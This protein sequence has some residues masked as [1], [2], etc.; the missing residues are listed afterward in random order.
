MKVQGSAIK[1]LMMRVLAVRPM[2]TVLDVLQRRYGAVVTYEEPVYECRCDLLGKVG[3]AQAR[4]AGGIIRLGWALE[5]DS[6]EQVLPMLMKTQIRPR[7]ANR[8][9]AVREAEAG[10]Y[11]VYPV[12]ARNVQGDLIPAKPLMSKRITLRMEK[13]TSAEAI[14]AVCAAV[15]NGGPPVALAP[16]S[17]SIAKTLERPL[18]EPLVAD[19]QEARDVLGRVLWAAA[20]ELSWQCLF[21][22]RTRKHR[23]VVYDPF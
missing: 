2:S 1:P 7:D 17:P 23:L 6:V 20:P 15:S 19:A 4:L 22:P 11:H 12:K 14:E 13:V 18:P 8:M 16:S 21:D 9:F 10:R 3:T 5:Q